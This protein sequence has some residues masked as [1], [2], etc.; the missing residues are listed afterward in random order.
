MSEKR[1][2]FVIDTS[3]YA[4]NFSR[5]LCAYVTGMW[6]NETQ[7]DYESDLFHEEV[8]GNPFEDIVDYEY[9]EFG[10]E[11][12]CLELS[13]PRYDKNNSVGIYMNQRPSDELIELLKERTKKWAKEGISGYKPKIKGFRLITKT[14]ITEL[15]SL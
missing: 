3:E 14:T 6:D 13:P 10:T 8:E 2:L 1:Y 9:G 15:E 7:G 4:G 5:E 12:Q 11:P